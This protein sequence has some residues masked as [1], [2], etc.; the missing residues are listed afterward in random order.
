MK[1]FLLL[2]ISLSALLLFAGC[3]GS[4][5]DSGYK[6][7]YI[8]REVTGLI[9]KDCDISSSDSD[10]DGMVQ[11]YISLLQT[12]TDDV[13]Y[14]KPIMGDVTILDY[15]IS[16]STLNLY[17]STDYSSMDAAAEV[18]CRA[19]VVKSVLQIPGIND[20]SFYVGDAP[21][22]DSDGNAVGIMTADSFVENPGSQINSTQTTTLT[23]YFTDESGEK[24]VPEVQTVHYISSISL[25][26]LV[27]EQLI[28]GP[29]T[30]QLKATIPTDTKIVSVTVTDGVCYVNLD[31]GFLVQDYNVS[32]QV[33]IYSIVDSLFELNNGIG[34][35]QISVN[36]ENNMVYR[37]SISLD[38][39]FTRNLDLIDSNQ[40]QTVQT[41]IERTGE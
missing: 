8:N 1:K 7:Y 17:F 9:E 6:I 27:V 38:Q 24:L 39:M 4:N 32:E 11:E 16:N 29:E 41:Q 33:V 15:S 25:E 20:V 37:E 40:E 13:E 22:M 35:V 3:E 26:K 18:L 23:L 19:A 12:E 34:K 5:E 14:Q 21:L 2:V 10:T 36:G 31:D 30:E 28:A